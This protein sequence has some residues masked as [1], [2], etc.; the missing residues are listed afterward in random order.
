[1]DDQE[2]RNLYLS[3]RTLQGV[4]SVPAVGLNVY[5]LVNCQ[6]LVISKRAILALQEALQE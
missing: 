5:D 4:K 2:N 1:V 6:H 3:A